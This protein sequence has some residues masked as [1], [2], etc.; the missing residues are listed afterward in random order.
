ME[1]IAKRPDITHEMIKDENKIERNG[2]PFKLGKSPN[3]TESII[4]VI[5]NTIL[6]L[7]SACFI[8]EKLYSSIK[9]AKSIC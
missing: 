9:D 8:R 7:D 1:S 4:P 2:D 5:H 3:K 6:A